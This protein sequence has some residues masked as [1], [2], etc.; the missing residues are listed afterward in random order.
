MILIWHQTTNS[1]MIKRRNT[2]APEVMSKPKNNGLF[3]D[4]WGSW[5]YLFAYL[6]VSA[7]WWRQN[8]YQALPPRSHLKRKII[9]RYQFH[10]GWTSGFLFSFGLVTGSYLYFTRF[11]ICYIFLFSFLLALF[12]KGHLYT[13]S[14]YHHIII[15]YISSATKLSP[16]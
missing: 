16:R 5:S 13:L 9:I 8:I 3:E 7:W 14:F 2:V 4:C 11:T 6:L 10:C 12:S 15:I 1:S